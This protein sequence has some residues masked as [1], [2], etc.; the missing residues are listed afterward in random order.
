MAHADPGVGGR[1]GGTQSG[2]RL[3]HQRDSGTPRAEHHLVDRRPP[4]RRSGRPGYHRIHVITAGTHAGRPGGDSR[5]TGR[6]GAAPA[7]SANPETGRQDRARQM[8]GQPRISR[9]RCGGSRRARIHLR[10]DRLGKVGDHLS[11]AHLALEPLPD[12]ISGD[13]SGQGGLSRPR[14][15]GDRWNARS[16]WSRSPT[17]GIAAVARNRHH[18]SSGSSR[19]CVPGCFRVAVAR[20]LRAG[21]DLRAPRRVRRI[22][23]RSQS[24]RRQVGVGIIDAH[25]RLPR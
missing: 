21:P 20:A 8:A 25:S 1:S 9:H 24:S 13:R 12:S 11:T 4:R 3:H 23:D 19:Q 15:N 17:L 10:T 18:H 22:V 14:R 2:R 6:R 5:P 16:S 7:Q